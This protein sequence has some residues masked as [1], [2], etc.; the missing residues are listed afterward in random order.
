MLIVEN[1][2]NVVSEEELENDSREVFKEDKETVEAILLEL[3]AWILSSAHL[4]DKIF[5]NIQ[6]NM[7]IIYIIL[8]L[9]SSSKFSKQSYYMKNEKYLQLAQNVRHDDLFL[10]KFLRGC[11]YSI[12]KTKDKLDLYFTA[13]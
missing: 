11:N 4:K 7:L 8:L 2:I 6:Y 1:H 9:S 12:A 10:R 5:F 3:R 13:R